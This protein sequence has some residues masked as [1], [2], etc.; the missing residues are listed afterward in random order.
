MIY[1]PI[2]KRDIRGTSCVGFQKGI[3]NTLRCLLSARV[4]AD[5]GFDLTEKPLFRIEFVLDL[6]PLLR[7]RFGYQKLGTIVYEVPCGRPAAPRYGSRSICRQSG[8][9]CGPRSA[10][11]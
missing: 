9:K 5:M 4:C 8:A 6:S 7:R 11:K 2:G 1:T 10:S 3:V